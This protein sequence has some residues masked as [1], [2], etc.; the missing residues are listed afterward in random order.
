VQRGIQVLAALR[1]PSHDARSR[2]VLFGAT[3]YGR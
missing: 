2:E 3:Q 1:K